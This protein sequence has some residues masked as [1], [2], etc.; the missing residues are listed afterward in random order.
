MRKRGEFRSNEQSDKTT[1]IS[2]E[3]SPLLTTTNN[4][5]LTDIDL[6]SATQN[7]EY[8]YECRL[9]DNTVKQGTRVLRS[10]QHH[11]RFHTCCNSNRPDEP[12]SD[13]A[14]TDTVSRRLCTSFNK[15]ALSRNAFNER[16]QGNVV[17]STN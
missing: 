9:Y 16:Q 3:A 5:L 14:I 10:Y 12:R 17:A 8:K 15:S 13:L 1:Y 4:L 6:P 2:F 7:R 11:T